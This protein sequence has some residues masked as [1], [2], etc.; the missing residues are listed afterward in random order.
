M[1]HW[2][3]CR[4]LRSTR[5]RQENA[6]AGGYTS[7]QGVFV[8]HHEQLYVPDPCQMGDCFAT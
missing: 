7:G 2:F 5:T 4:N 3:L 6:L 8:E 1:I